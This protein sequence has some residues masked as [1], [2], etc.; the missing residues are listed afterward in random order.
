MG[1]ATV[2]YV[3]NSGNR[4]IDS[5][6]WGSRWLSQAPG[7]TVI[8]VGHAPGATSAEISAIKSVLSE[9][10]RVL[11]VTFNF[12]GVD[13]NRNADIKFVFSSTGSKT[14]H[15]EGLPPGQFY[16]EPTW[17]PGLTEVRINRSAYTG[18]LVPGT[19]DY[20]TMLHEFSHA[21]G[22]AHPHDTG[23][24]W[25]DKSLIFPGVTAAFG[26]YGDYNLNQGIFTTMSYNDGWKTGGVAGLQASLMA[27]DIQALQYIYGANTSYAAGNDTYVLP[28]TNNGFTSIWD[29]GGTDVMI[30]SGARSVTLDLRAATGLVS[31]GGGGFV[32]HVAGLNGGY[33]I[34]VGAIIENA[35]GGSG[36]D[37]LIGNAMANRL[38]GNGG[39]DV[40]TGGGGDD[41]FV[42]SAIVHSGLSTLTADV[43][44]DFMPGQDNLDLSR[45]DGNA[46]I[47]GMQDFIFAGEAAGFAAAGQ[48]RV[49]QSGGQ[50]LVLLNTDN[51]QAAES[52]IILDG[53]VALTD[54]DFIF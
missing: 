4:L 28:R 54:S 44:T 32:S 43:I 6:V 51:D 39:R 11:N 3:G 18:P 19:T 14:V 49:V 23:G 40:L 16:L 38:T 21:M 52:M 34:A 36:A 7:P 47:S 41:Y 35:T 46:L 50:T 30:Y 10:S 8:T 29:T 26:S 2:A 42:F 37:I 9:F 13:S 15:G 25:L 12:M 22:L 17:N 48:I 45:L 20:V 31:E 1:T 5:L 53:L 33:T 24:T 27:L